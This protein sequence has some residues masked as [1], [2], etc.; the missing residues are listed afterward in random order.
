VNREP[1]AFFPEQTL[2]TP[3]AGSESF[4]QT[5]RPQMGHVFVAGRPHRL[6]IPIIDIAF[7]EAGT[8]EIKSSKQDIG[9][10]PHRS[11]M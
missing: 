4:A 8:A 7:G 6:Q 3:V 2:Q 10:D 1:F 11:A 9:R 5:S